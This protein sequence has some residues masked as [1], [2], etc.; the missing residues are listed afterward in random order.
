MVFWIHRGHYIATYLNRILFFCQFV[1]KNPNV[2]HI[3][4]I[5]AHKH[6]ITPLS[7]VQNAKKSRA[8]DCR[9]YK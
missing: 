9:P 7:I 8:A 6:P 3:F 4:H 2:V 5:S 1:K